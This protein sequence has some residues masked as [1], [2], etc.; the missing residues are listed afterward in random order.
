MHALLFPSTVFVRL[1]LTHFFSRTINYRIG[2]QV[3]LSLSLCMC[4]SLS[5]CHS[6]DGGER[7]SGGKS[8]GGSGSKNCVKE[9]DGKKIKIKIK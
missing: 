6:V 9:R 1:L 8:G 5:V 4:V 7:K 3:S 2:V